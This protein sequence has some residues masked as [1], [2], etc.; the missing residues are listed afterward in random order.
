MW[1]HADPKWGNYH[2]TVTLRVLLISPS[3]IMEK[4]IK[5]FLRFWSQY[6]ENLNNFDLNDWDYSISMKLFEASFGLK[7][8]S[9]LKIVQIVSLCQS[10]YLFSYNKMYNYINILSLH[11]N[12]IEHLN[13][14]VVLQTITSVS[15]ALEW[16]RHTFLYS[17]VMKNPKHYGEFIAM[18]SNNFRIIVYH[19]Q[20]HNFKYTPLQWNC[21]EQV[22]HYKEAKCVSDLSLT[23][24]CCFFF[25]H[26][27]HEKF[28]VRQRIDHRANST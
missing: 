22:Q 6:K 3:K 8:C 20:L 7:K 4:L 5:F 25:G 16:I 2:E 24:G 13:A 28:V 21:L 18:L 27:W 15:L 17:R 11:K 12:L 19:Y 10:Q 14:E 1:Y 23:C 26:L 9:L